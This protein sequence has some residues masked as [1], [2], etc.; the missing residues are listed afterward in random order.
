M[1]KTTTAII[2][3]LAMSLTACASPRKQVAGELR[4]LGVGKRGAECMAHEMDDRLRKR[5]MKA[6]AKFLDGVNAVSDDRKRRPGKVAI[7][8]AGIEN[9]VI[10]RAA[11]KASVSCTILR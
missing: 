3:L 1:T 2:L 4:D 6:L 8:F 10:A 5:E 11:A 9:P 7:L